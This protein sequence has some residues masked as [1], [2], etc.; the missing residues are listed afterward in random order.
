MKYVDLVEKL[1]AEDKEKIANYIALYGSAKEHFIGVD[2]WLQNWSHSNQKLYHLLGDQLIRKFDY[3]YEKSSNDIGIDIVNKLFDTTFKK[4]YHEF[5]VKVIRKLYNEGE[6]SLDQKTGFN[7]LSD[8]INF[9]DDKVFMGIKY[10]KPN[11]TRTLQ[12]A[13]GTK[14]MRAFAK[15]IEYFKDDFEFEGFE[16]FRVMHAKILNDKKVK[17]ELC[18]SIHPLDYMTMSDN[19]L[20]WSSCMSWRNE[21]CYHVG[22]IE[23]MNSNNVLCGYL[24]SKNDTFWFKD[25]T[26]DPAYSWNNKKWRCLVYVTKDI[27]MNG[28][29]YPYRN[30]ELSNR[31]ITNVRDLAKENLNW[32]YTFGIEPYSDMKY[33][34]SSFTM[35]RAKDYVHINPRKHNIIWDTKG[36]YNDMLNDHQAGYFCYRNKVKK[37]KVIC[38]SGKANCLCCNSSIIEENYSDDYNERYSCCGTAICNECENEYFR[39]DLCENSNNGELIKINAYHLEWYRDYC[40]LEKK[41]LKVCKKCYGTHARLCP[42]CGRPIWVSDFDWNKAASFAYASATNS[43]R[44]YFT[45]YYWENY[46]DYIFPLICCADCAKKFIGKTEM[47]P[48]RFSWQ[49]IKVVIP[50]IKDLSPEEEEKYYFKN[51]KKIENFSVTEFFPCGYD[52]LKTE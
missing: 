2:K 20:N 30:D 39:C 14:P 52:S 36:M 9:I 3:Y 6:M 25:G 44:G 13:P 46:H 5:Y 4:S 16:D 51:L 23:M 22:T 43:E 12:I 34:N 26:D 10:K 21:G 49:N 48:A 47:R 40:A 17:G 24:S 15:V 27:I 1:S 18:V 11:A 31:L 50:C 28:K 19:S 7:T 38:V 42:D 45:D 32:N 37:N 41:T 33:I 29:A 8:R 35:D